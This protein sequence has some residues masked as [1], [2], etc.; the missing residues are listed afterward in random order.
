MHFHDIWHEKI[1]SRFNVT[2]DMEEMCMSGDKIVLVPQMRFGR[3]MSI[4]IYAL[5]SIL[6]KKYD[7][8][9]INYNLLL[10]KGIINN[11]FSQKKDL[12]NVANHII[13]LN[14]KV[15][16][17]SSIIT[18]FHIYLYIS[19]V[20]KSIN[21]K[22]KCVF[23]GPQPSAVAYETIDRFPWVDAVAIGESEE[24]ITSLME[25][26]INGRD[27]ED[28]PGVV[29]QGKRNV[30]KTHQY[31]QDLSTLDIIDYSSF[32]DVKDFFGSTSSNRRFSIETGRGCPFKC[33]FC[34]S[35]TLTNS[36]YRRKSNER[37]IE[38]V[39]TLHKEH[40]L[41]SF[42]FC[43]DLFTFNKDLIINFCD[44]LKENNLSIQWLATARIDTI[45]AEMLQ[46][47]VDSGCDELQFG[48]ESGSD[49]I[50]TLI[51]KNLKSKEI[52]EKINLLRKSGITNPMFSF[53][54]GFPQETTED[55]EK[56]LDII[57]FLIHNDFL[58]IE[59]YKLVIFNAT[60]IYE[61][62]KDSIS[63]K[64]YFSILRYAECTQEIYKDNKD[65]FPY[66]WQLDTYTLNNYPFMDLFITSFVLP[67]ATTYKLISKALFKNGDTLLKL[68]ELLMIYL[69][70]HSLTIRQ[71]SQQNL[72]DLFTIASAKLWDKNT[73]NF[74]YEIYQYERGIAIL[75]K[76]RVSEYKFETD[77]DFSKIDDIDFSKLHES[78]YIINAIKVL[79][80]GKK[81]I[82]TL[83][84][85]KNKIM[86]FLG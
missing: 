71:I 52:Y 76:G 82:L 15:V 50:Q 47:M 19:K 68:Y 41:T 53:I 46:K 64:G 81:D 32:F 58:N 42:R 79:S 59:F 25:C 11:D 10:E 31:V 80:L 18:D 84:R 54:Y 63:D 8:T 33:T 78:S 70:E 6:Q 27:Y 23:G 83:K 49:K 35:S 39:T 9:C 44:L 12:E 38:E 45:D 75:K 69:N 86:V 66:M 43:H 14:P 77:I 7:V 28:I 48:I 61:T 26:L 24:N 67:I 65:I 51:N 2:K 22:I 20:I 3:G 62:E 21:K 37:I 1:E 5:A 72:D 55:L 56:T 74:F 85:E 17:F 13:S 4:G 30:N 29:F 36:K 16:G 40:G 60:K 57:A 34:Y 73:H